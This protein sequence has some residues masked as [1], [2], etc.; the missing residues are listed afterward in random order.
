MMGFGFFGLV[1]M[2]ITGNR[3]ETEFIAVSCHDH[4]GETLA[5]ET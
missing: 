4:E 2:Q 1:P 5:I 3:S